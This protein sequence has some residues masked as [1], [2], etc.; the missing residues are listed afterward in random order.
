MPKVAKRK[1]SFAI[2]SRLGSSNEPTNTLYLLS[3][4]T[5]T[6]AGTSTLYVGDL[7]SDSGNWNNYIYIIVHW[8]SSTKLVWQREYGNRAANAPRRSTISNLS[9]EYGFAKE[10]GMWIYYNQSSVLPKSR[11][12]AQVDKN[13]IGGPSTLQFTRQTEASAHVETAIAQELSSH[14]P[15]TSVASIAMIV[16]R[17]RHR[18]E[19]KTDNAD[20]TEPKNK[21]NLVDC[22]ID[23]YRCCCCQCQ[24]LENSRLLE[25]VV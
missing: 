15:I 22:C 9:R 8:T 17:A 6:L 24:E 1:N 11:N 25:K 2:N 12:S 16:S 18:F 14:Q 13:E 20:N 23:W 5:S 10:I 3:D 19:S 4:M 7:T 21:S